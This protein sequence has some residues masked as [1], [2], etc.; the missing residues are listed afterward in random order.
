MQVRISPSLLAADFGRLREAA[1]AAE[2]AG[3]CAIHVDYMDGHYVHNFSFGIDLISALKPYLSIPI[4][5]HLEIRNPDAFIADFAAAGADVIV[6][7][8]DTC[9]NLPYTIEAIL[10]QGIAAG[11]GVNPDRTFRRFEAHP[12]LLQSIA[13]LIVMGVYPG[14]GGQVFAATTL[15]NVAL[16]ARLRTLHNASYEIGVDGGVSHATVGSL[17]AA[18]ASYLIAGSS[19]FNG[20]LE[21][22]PANVASLMAAATEHASC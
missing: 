6:V 12:H 15:E 9:P 10:E 4:V 1:I 21:A 16:A 13:L 14:F 8:E 2:A 3:G 22:L 20:S 7:Q 17:V 5:A 18:G 19:V 11:V